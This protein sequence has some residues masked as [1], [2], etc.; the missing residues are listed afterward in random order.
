MGFVLN[1]EK[2]ENV[3]I[4]H[5]VKMVNIFETKVVLMEEFTSKNSKKELN[6]T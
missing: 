5:F 6:T 1:V 3:E 4:Y 2:V